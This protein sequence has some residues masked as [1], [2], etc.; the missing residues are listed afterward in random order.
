MQ[1]RRKTNAKYKFANRQNGKDKLLIII[2]GYKKYTYESVFS[3][4]EKYV[5][6]DTDVCIVSSGLYDQRLSEIALKNKWSYLSLERNCV[7]LAQNVAILLHP[8]AQYIYKMDEDIFITQGCM[9]KMFETY[10]NFAGA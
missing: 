8:H 6:A 1:Y 5:L 9:D 4:V 10:S 2:A 7:C 3:R